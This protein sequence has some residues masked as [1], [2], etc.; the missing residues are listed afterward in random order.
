[1]FEHL[2]F[3]VITLHL[4]WL[5]MRNNQITYRSL[6]NHLNPLFNLDTQLLEKFKVRTI[7]L[8]GSDAFRTNSH[9]LHSLSSSPF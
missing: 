3:T 2:V 1:M 4:K 6:F 7:A 8:M 9:D 5:S